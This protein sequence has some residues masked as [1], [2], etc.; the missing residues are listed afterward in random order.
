MKVIVGS[1]IVGKSNAHKNKVGTVTSIQK[2]DGKL[3]YSVNWGVNGENLL[4]EMVAK[5]AF[6]LVDNGVVRRVP[7]ARVANP[8]IDSESGS[9]DT[10]SD[11]DNSASEEENAVEDNN[12]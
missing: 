8:A 5:N 7:R 10:S 1:R 3:R 9:S 6:N 4:N 11:D 12:L 2:V